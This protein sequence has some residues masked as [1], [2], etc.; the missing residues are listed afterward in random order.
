MQSGNN[1]SQAQWKQPEPDTQF[2][3]PK[4]SITSKEN[5]LG[6][7]LVIAMRILKK[8]TKYNTQNVKAQYEVILK[9]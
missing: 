9:I 7:S 8:P 3:D 2:S 6:I 5:D 1:N 4:L